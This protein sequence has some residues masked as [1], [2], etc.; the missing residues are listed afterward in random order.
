VSKATDAIR[1]LVRTGV[2]LGGKAIIASAMMA[3]PIL[4]LPIISHVFKW[5]VNWVVSKL[6]VEPA[7][8]NLLVDFTIDIERNAK[9]EAYE[10]ARDELKAVLATNIRNKKDLQKASDDF[11]ARFDALVH[12]DP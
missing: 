11:D 8:A 7:L 4:K 5:L 6:E 2:G 12:L 10:Q 9:K 1:A 3:L